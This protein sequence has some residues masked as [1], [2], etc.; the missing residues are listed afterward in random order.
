[1]INSKGTFEFPIEAWYVPELP[2]NTGPADF[3]GLPGLIVEVKVKSSIGYI[4]GLKNI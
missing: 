2:Y 3:E 1:M 4:L